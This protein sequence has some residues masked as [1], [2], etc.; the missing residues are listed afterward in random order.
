[1]TLVRT[2]K[3][4]LKGD[5]NYIA[6]EMREVVKRPALIILTGPLGVG[7]TTFVQSFVSQ[8]Q[9]APSP[10]YSLINESGEV[11][12]ADF[13]R[14]KEA[15]E[16]DHLELGLYLEDKQFFLVEWGMPYLQELRKLAG[17]SFTFYELEMSMNE[18][19]IA[20]GELQS[21]NYILRDID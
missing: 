3:K 19:A 14:I 13:F 17:D 18:K 4:V 10:T 8:G 15:R 5:L 1:M 7:K 2:W 9:L 21:R 20:E 11:A 16:L 12:H 6:N